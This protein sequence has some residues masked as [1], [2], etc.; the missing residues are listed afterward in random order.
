FVVEDASNL[1]TKILEWG[2]LMA[3]LEQSTRYIFYDTV[4]AEGKYKYYTPNLP[5]PLRARYESALDF[6]FKLYSETVRGVTAYVR[7]KFP[8]PAD[9]KERT[10]WL[11]ATRAQACDAA[12]P[13]LPAATK[14]TVGHVGSAQAVES[15]VRHL[16]A[17]PLE[18]CRKVGVDILRETRKVMPAFLKRA[19]LPERGLAWA[20]YNKE[21]ARAVWEIAGR[22]LP[23]AS[24]DFGTEVRLLDYTPKNELDLVP[25]MLFAQSNISILEIRQVVDA[26]SEEKK[27]E[28][29][30]AYIGNRLNRRHKPGR[31]IERAH[32]EWEVTGDYGTFRDLQRHR[33]VDAWEWQNLTCTYGYDVPPLIIEAGFEEQFRKCFAMS[34]GLVNELKSA[35]YVDE[36]Q[37]AVLMGYKLRYRFILNARAA[38]HFH[39]LRTGPQ[40]H[41]GYR[42]I[43]QEMHNQLTRVHPML[44]AAMKFVNKSGDPELTRLE[45]ERA[46]L[47]KLALL[48]EKEK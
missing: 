44:G 36:A 39:E 6:N 23:E 25:E 45:S 17:H 47:M 8:E 5:V 26:W 19:D 15:L 48:D 28:V 24:H 29:F 12:R 10:A 30:L 14:S 32:Y 27:K 42:R 13:T 2:R 1:L 7:Q 16:F 35:G 37:Y 22:N 21:T 40:G 18:E 20:L 34:D 4:N 41:P 9:P 11:G 3:Y 43:V 46:T 31:A 33:M 38:F